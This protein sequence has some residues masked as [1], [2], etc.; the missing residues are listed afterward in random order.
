LNLEPETYFT[1]PFRVSLR[2]AHPALAFWAGFGLLD[3]KEPLATSRAMRD[4]SYPNTLAPPGRF[5]PAWMRRTG[6]KMGAVRVVGISELDW[7]G[8][9]FL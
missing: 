9:V 3:P 8:N 7:F 6:P 5:A 4:G 2:K 1:R